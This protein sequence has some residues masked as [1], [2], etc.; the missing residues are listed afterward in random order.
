V[1]LDNALQLFLD[2]S[3]A[4]PVL[5]QAMTC[6]EALNWHDYFWTPARL[7]AWLDEPETG[8]SSPSVCTADPEVE[9][10]QQ[11]CSQQ[12]VPRHLRQLLIL[13]LQ[14]AADSGHAQ[15]LIWT[16]TRL[17]EWL[18]DHEQAPY[19]SCST[20]SGSAEA[21]AGHHAGSLS[22]IQ[23]PVLPYM[24]RLPLVSSV[25]ASKA[26]LASAADSSS[27]SDTCD[28]L[29]EACATGLDPIMPSS[30]CQQPSASCAE[31]AQPQSAEAGELA[32]CP[33]PQ[34]QPLHAAV[35]EQ[36]AEQATMPDSNSEQEVA[37][38]TTSSVHSHQQQQDQTIST[39]HA[40][41][42]EPSAPAH[43]TDKP[44]Q[45]IAASQVKQQQQQQQLLPLL[46]QLHA[47]HQA[48]AGMQ[49]SR[50]QPQDAALRVQPAAAAQLPR[51]EALP[52]D[53]EA[54]EDNPAWDAAGYKTAAAAAALRLGLPQPDT[55]TG[56]VS[57]AA[58]S[59]AGAADTANSSS[60]TQ[61]PP[62]DQPA[63][64]HTTK[65]PQGPRF[66]VLMLVHEKGVT[67]ADVWE[68][69]ECL[70]AGKAVVRVHLKAGVTTAGL[71]GASWITCRQLPSR[72]CSQWG[73]IS[74]TGAILQAAA[75]LL[76]Q[77]PE[78]QHVALVSGQ[79]LPVAA[80]PKDL[81]PG[82]SLFGRF[83][84]GRAFDDAA[85][86]VAR[87]LLQQQL[88]M[89]VREAKAWGD[90]LVFHHTWM[91][92]D[93]WEGTRCLHRRPFNIPACISH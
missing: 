79:D 71:P 9:V 3:Q 34:Q 41:M 89:S 39:A 37:G 27:A 50:Q 28:G 8:T 43:L 21:A 16:P 14:Q 68:S 83:Q 82:L 61:V 12:L 36:D 54:V 77:H 40:L 1:Q 88:A 51:K 42:Q 5:Q 2:Q 25:V 72:I 57:C 84:F 44:T 60:S 48:A 18:A 52:G 32:V 91:V 19:S 7:D 92:L 22:C 6:A 67:A 26:Q 86:Q 75:D 62:G 46:Q 64:Q 38:D 31:Q 13:L 76:Q 47:L 93:R 81:R 80:V 20:S 59:T 85:R 65:V 55:A 4:K 70:H 58:S 78:L 11:E 29:M 66:G 35:P 17:A 33:P 69:W 15:E 23:Q 24:Q 73:C 56:H 45:P 74:L 63:Q 10:C 90:A 49:C 30:S 87:E 53:Y